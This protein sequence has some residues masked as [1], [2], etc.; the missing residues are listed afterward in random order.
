MSWLYSLIVSGLI[1]STGS[2]GV[3]SRYLAEESTAFSATSVVE[4]SNLQTEV[5]D[6]FE[7]TYK[8]SSNG[9]VSVSNINGSISVEGWDQNEIKLE[10]IKIAD[11]AETL[12]EA[13]IKVSERTDHLRIETDI[14]NMRYTG[15]DRR[16]KIEV[17]YKLMVPRSVELDGIETVNGSVLIKGVNGAAK[18]SAVNGKVDAS[19]LKGNAELSTVNGEVEAIFVSIEAGSRI[20]LNTVNGSV[21][22]SLPSDLNATI[23]AESLNGVI[24]NEFGLNVKRGEYIGRNLHGMCGDGSSQIKLNSIN[25]PLTILRRK[26]GRTLTPAVDLQGSTSNDES[27]RVQDMR[28]SVAEA[29]RQATN[30]ARTS[31]KEAAEAMKMAQVEMAKIQP[32]LAKMQ[33]QLKIEGLNVE[34]EKGLLEQTRALARMTNVSWRNPAPTVNRRS[35]TFDVKDTPKVIIEAVD[36]DIVVRGVDTSTVR[37]VLSEYGSPTGAEPAGFTEDKNGNELKFRVTGNGGPRFPGMR[38][39]NNRVRLEVFVPKRTDLSVKTDGEVR[40]SNIS[41]TIDIKGE[42][43]SIDVRDSQGK[44]ILNAQDGQIRVVGFNGSVDSNIVDGELYLDGNFD[45]LTSKAI[46]GTITLTVPENLNAEMTSSAD[47]E[48]VGFNVKNE[49]KRKII[50]GNGSSKFNFDFVDGRLLVRS[51]KTIIV[52]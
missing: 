41:G 13:E 12:A 45:G 7:A 24:S 25:G 39:Q 35:A 37:Y 8:I 21:K 9:R 2:D 32:E 17:N 40:V 20:S 5:T 48:T 23:K 10:A 31:Q 28:R 52:E 42:D 3:V 22:V 38:L 47:I 16:R 49:S 18:A 15:Q 34:I 29:N 46:D 14:K 6:K 43:E 44:L 1:L 26:D 36:C 19:E 50:F 4:V 51:S 30:A 27:V 11:S 33:S